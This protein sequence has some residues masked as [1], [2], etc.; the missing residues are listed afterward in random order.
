MT[1]DAATIAE[2]WRIMGEI[3]VAVELDINPHTGA[4][5]AVTLHL[6]G[7]YAIKLSM[8]GMLVGNDDWLQNLVLQGEN[9]PWLLLQHLFPAIA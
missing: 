8:A 4:A 2:M 5:L 7:N 9:E 6:H 3:P 1:A